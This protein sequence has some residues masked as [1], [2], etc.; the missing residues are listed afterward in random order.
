MFTPKK[1]Q[2]QDGISTTSSYEEDFYAPMQRHWVQN[3]VT[4]S[5]EDAPDLTQQL[6]ELYR[7]AVS[8]IE[9]KGQAK[10]PSNIKASSGRVKDAVDTTSTTLPAAHADGSTVQQKPALQQDVSP[11]NLLHAAIDCGKTPQSPKVRNLCLSPKY[12]LTIRQYQKLRSLGV[13]VVNYP[14]KRKLLQHMHK[15]HWSSKVADKW[16]YGLAAMTRFALLELAEV[17]RYDAFFCLELDMVVFNPFR[18]LHLLAYVTDGRKRARNGLFFDSSSSSCTSTSKFCDQGEAKTL[19][20]EGAEE[21]TQ[22]HPKF[23]SVFFTNGDYHFVHEG[24]LI[25]TKIRTPPKREIAGFSATLEEQL[26]QQSDEIESAR[27]RS[28]TTTGLDHTSTAVLPSSTRRFQNRRKFIESRYLVFEEDKKKEIK[29][30]PEEEDSEKQDPSDHKIPLQKSNRLVARVTTQAAEE[31]SPFA[32]ILLLLE[33]LPVTETQINENRNFLP[34]N[35]SVPKTDLH[36]GLNGFY[37]E[38][39][40]G[41]GLLYV[42]FRSDALRVLEPFVLDR[43]QWNYY[44]EVQFRSKGRAIKGEQLYAI[45]EKHQGWN[46]KKPVEDGA[47]ETASIAL[48]QGENAI[49]VD[50]SVIHPSPRGAHQLAVS[51]FYEPFQ[52]VT[53]DLAVEEQKYVLLQ[54]IRNGVV[55]KGEEVRGAEDAGQVDANTTWMGA[56]FRTTSLFEQNAENPKADQEKLPHVDPPLQP[57]PHAHQP[58]GWCRT[59]SLRP[60]VND[61]EYGMCLEWPVEIPDHG[62]EARVDRCAAYE[63]PPVIIHKMER[64]LLL[65]LAYYQEEFRHCSHYGVI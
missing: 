55:G 37:D 43:C 51:K 39:G 13:H 59:A 26:S 38:N 65:Q 6:A 53:Q 21:Q 60:L 45:D 48:E 16:R 18:V 28:G 15:S 31:L 62:L 47:D 44:L 27:A 24:F 20:M 22:E 23:D 32:R 42:F 63:G 10:D 64:S 61:P 8:H 56:L 9:Q 34:D 46:A 19:S 3:R 36:N 14:L 4:E 1:Y 17:G 5:D 11:S 40:I 30:S 58:S 25:F 7:E 12:P 29:Q 35:R 54:Q 50:D 33:Y 2:T 49:E 41:A 57:F 52:R